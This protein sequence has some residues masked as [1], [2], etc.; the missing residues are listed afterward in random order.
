MFSKY[1]VTKWGSNTG[2]VIGGDDQGAYAVADPR[3]AWENRRNNLTVVDWQEASK[4]IIGG[5]K[6]VQGGWLSVADPRLQMQRNKGD[7]YLTAGHY[8]VVP[9]E[10]ACGAVSA[11]A[12][13]DNG[14]WNVAD[15][16]IP[17]AND[18]LVAVIRSL[19]GTWHRPFTT[20]ELAALQS[21]IDPDDIIDL[22]GDSDGAKRERIGNAV[23][24]GAAQAI[25]DL[26]GQT[27]L[28]A[29]SGQTFQLSATPIWVKPVAVAM[30]VNTFSGV[31]A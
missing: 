24:P 13:Y 5:G 10:R 18:K 21:L 30:A 12:S 28:L 19:D 29:W 27:L 2:T 7:D 25:A 8:G 6:G 31:T 1:A 4:T 9:W 20:L 23:P 17:A 16:R 15:P 22:D 26:M 11:A 14:R 3:P